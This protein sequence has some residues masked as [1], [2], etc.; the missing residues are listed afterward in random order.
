M[1][2][3]KSTLREPAQ[4]I[5]E[6]SDADEK[7][8]KRRQKSAEYRRCLLVAERRAAIKAR[9]RQWDPPKKA[10]AAACEELLRGPSPLASAVNCSGVA[11]SNIICDSDAEDVSYLTSAEQFALSVLVEMSEARVAE[12]GV[13]E[14]IVALTGKYGLVLKPP[15]PAAPSAQVSRSPYVN[16]DG[17]DSVLELAMQLSSISSRPPSHHSSAAA[18][19][20]EPVRDPWNPH[21]GPRYERTLPAY[22][23]PATPLQKKIHRELGLLGPLTPV[24]LAQIDVGAL[25]DSVS[26]NQAEMWL[27]ENPETDVWRSCLTTE[28]I[29]RIWKWRGH[30]VYDSEWDLE[31]RRGFAEATLRQ[32]AL[33]T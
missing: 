22:A 17:V 31:A 30:E 28:G 11:R 29:Q 18:V 23:S 25:A 21:P 10:K 12:A 15:P 32:R 8:E 24:Q 6:R 16:S 33:Y 2:K 3:R 14:Q 1:S 19:Q 5:G 20:E 27:D 7:R 13:A 26:E 9:R 4:L